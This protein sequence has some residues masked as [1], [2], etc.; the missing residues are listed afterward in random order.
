MVKEHGVYKFVKKDGEIIYIGKTNNTFKSRID[1]HI[2]A[3]GDDIKFKK[4]ENQYDV[5]YAKLP[6][7]T[8]T[9]ILEKALINKYKP[10]LNVVDNHDGIGTLIQVTEPE[11]LEYKPQKEII[12]YHYGSKKTKNPKLD[13]RYEEC[14]TKFYYAFRIG[15]SDEEV[16]W[17]NPQGVTEIPEGSQVLRLIYVLT[18]IVIKY[19]EEF[20]DDVWIDMEYLQKSTLLREYLKKDEL[21]TTR[22]MLC[23]RSG[24]K[25]PSPQYFLFKNKWFDQSKQK[26]C[27]IFDRTIINFFRNYRSVFHVE[28]GN[29]NE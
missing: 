13:W 14:T 27:I 3:R 7:R 18:D 2:R 15:E 11:W 21:L 29:K 12:K 24:V 8:E 9:D 19:G 16:F 5:F 23:S 10:V 22:F 28:G 6:N 17:A 1:A 26:W 4:Y 20:G 25:R